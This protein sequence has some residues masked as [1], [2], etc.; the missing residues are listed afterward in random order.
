MSNPGSLRNA[1]IQHSQP[2]AISREGQERESHDLMTAALRDALQRED[3]LLSEKRDLLRRQETLAQEFEHRLSNSLQLISS[4]LT[5]QCRTATTPEVAA[6]LSVAAHRVCAVGRVHCRLHL[7]D[8]Q[9][10]VEFKQYLRDLCDDLAVLL[11]HDPASR[12][13]IVQSIDFE[14]PTALGIPLGFIVN[15]LITNAAKYAKGNIIVR[16]ET[17][18]PGRGYSLSVLDD[19]PGLPA[20]FDPANG[21]GLGMKIILLLVRQIGGELHILPSDNACGARFKITFRSA[22]PGTSGSHSFERK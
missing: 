10:K 22:N 17:T 3:A 2:R 20:G 18:T 1:K 13:I 6:Q 16:I 5:L 4:M 15:E 21:K 11:F 19:G 7:L 9:E 8:H 14:I 12:S